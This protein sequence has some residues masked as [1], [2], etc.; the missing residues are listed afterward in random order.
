MVDLDR[1]GEVARAQMVESLRRLGVADEPV[2]EVMASVPRHR[3]VD[4]FWAVA[5]GARW[6]ARSVREFVV[7]EGCSDE[8][9]H[10][11]HDVLVAVAI[12][13]PIDEP[14][15]TSSIS[16]PVIVASML[17]EMALR[18]GLRVLEVGTGSGYNVALIAELVGDPSLVTTVEID[19]TL[20]AETAPRLERLGY[21][22]IYVIGGDGSEGVAERAPFD[23]VLATVG[24]VD[25]AP[26]WIDQLAGGGELL[27]PLEH[28]AMHP[29]VAVRKSE[30]GLHG[31]FVGRSGFVRIQGSQARHQIWPHQAPVRAHLRSEPLPSPLADALAPP[32]PGRA[33]WTQ[34]LWDFDTYLGIRDRQAGIRDRRAATG[35]GLSDGTSLAMVRGRTVAVG[36]PE[37]GHLRDRLLTIGQQWVHLG[38]PGQGRY[39][40]VFTSRDDGPVPPDTPAGPWALDR[41]DYRQHVTLAP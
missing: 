16:A 15:A 18:H 12:R 35:P 37:G 7:D 20:V 11:L 33:H 31:R 10:L 34:K 14:V 39:A 27:L 17:T 1:R 25:I 3:F 19:P 4:R 2:L 41:I 23:R 24:C 8:T 6:T 30:G 38:C 29:R 13:G 40:L 28:G 21:G 26:A 22:A 36:G 9:L 5:R 32:D